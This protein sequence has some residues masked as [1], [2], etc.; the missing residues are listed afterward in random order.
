MVLL[1]FMIG[2][3]QLAYGPQ[4]VKGE[5][6]ISIKSFL[7]VCDKIDGELSQEGNENAYT[8][9]FVMSKQC[10]VAKVCY[11]EWSLWEKNLVNLQVITNECATSD[12]PEINMATSLLEFD[13]KIVGYLMPYVEGNT[14]DDII[15]RRL[16]TPSQILCIF[17]QIA[18]VINKLPT[19]ISIGDLHSRNIL[20]TNKEQVKLVD[21]DGFSVSNGYT[22]TCPLRY[23]TLCH[24][25]LPFSKYFHKDGSTKIGK[26][27]DIYC[28]CQM[29]LSW[30]L[31]GLN[32]F[33]FSKR[34][35]H[36]FLQYLTLKGI[37]LSVVKMF[38]TVTN[39]KENYMVHLPFSTFD[40]VVSDISYTDYIN[41]MNLREEEN[42]YEKYIN[43]LIIE[44]RKKHG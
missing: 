6:M 19:N 34:R 26:N 11:K 5:E 44:G 40:D 13:N 22:M 2:M 29:F 43:Q 1:T 17:D 42:C 16:K 39:E 7:D 31:G 30:L 28:L 21:I 36:L 10:Q 20:V 33:F 9:L 27:T 12:F 35:F 4:I 8:R 14:F 38:E 24:E 23:E 15:K 18:T 41:T 32:P 37:P 25:T 3:V